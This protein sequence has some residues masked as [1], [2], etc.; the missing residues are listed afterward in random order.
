MNKFYKAILTILF[1]LVL[2]PTQV[3]KAQSHALPIL[4]RNA[5][6]RSAAMG[7]ISAMSTDCNY[8]YINPTSI[9]YGDKKLTISANGLLFNHPKIEG[10][11][12]KLMYTNLSAGWRFL[13]RHAA[14]AG[15]RYEGGLK[16]RGAASGQFEENLKKFT[17]PFEWAVDLGYAFRFNN[18][19]A[20]FASGSFIQS[21]SGRTAMAGAFSIGANYLTSINMGSIDAKLNAIAKIADFG[22]PVYYSS[23]DAYSLPTYAQISGDLMMPLAEKHQLNVAL[24]GK[25]YFLPTDAQV[26]QV[27]LGAEYTIFNLVSLRAGY[28]Y[29]SRDTNLWGAGIGAKFYDVKLDF[30]YQSGISDYKVS[31]LM[32]TLSFD[33]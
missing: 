9:L 8:L 21:Y 3:S 26:I 22:T 33:Y 7:N 1:T 13:D 28:Q 11:E 4:G 5:D 27:G 16:I 25:Y 29:G 31:R 32:M 24:G 12:G 19:L 30:A 20:A 14:Y 17:T 6:A 10:I 2:V 23:K 15:F 18:T